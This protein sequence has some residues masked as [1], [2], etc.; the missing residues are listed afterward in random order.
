M[1]Y[2]PATFDVLPPMQQP[3]KTP[4]AAVAITV[5]RRDLP[6]AVMEGY[7]YWSMHPSFGIV[8]RIAQFIL[9]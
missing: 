8:V 7:R 1:G 6:Y 2:D 5:P 4:T 3:P 9:L